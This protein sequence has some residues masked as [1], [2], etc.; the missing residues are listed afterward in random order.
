MSKKDA[1][2]DSERIAREWVKDGV[3]FIVFVRR[4]GTSL[5]VIH[6]IIHGRI[7]IKDLKRIRR[8]HLSRG[9]KEYRFKKGC[10][11]WNNGIHFDAGGRSHLTRFKAG[12][13]RGAA[14]RQYKA[15][16]AITIRL[17]K[18][19]RKSEPQCGR[20]K[21]KVPYRYIKISD[22]GM[23]QYCWQ[24]YARY[25]W[26]KTFGPIPQGYFP[27][28]KDKDTLNDDPANLILVN[29]ADNLRRNGHSPQ[30]RVYAHARAVEHRKQ[31]T[32]IRKSSKGLQFPRPDQFECPQCG[33]SS[34][35]KPPLDLCPKCNSG[36]VEQNK[37]KVA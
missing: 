5:S 18:S 25:I 3:A 6:D 15:V 30:V 35:A 16:G 12:Q 22:T 34:D 31:N 28:H 27:I 23:P 24:E 2:A 7:K 4:Y 14:A 37:V 17:H 11:A 10:Q 21:K 8:E 1:I 19:K 33:W 9:G 20:P 36:V 32:L 29:R 13:I 26:E